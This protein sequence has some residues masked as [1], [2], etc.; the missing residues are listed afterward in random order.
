[1]D[2]L[3]IIDE[4]GGKVVIVRIGDESYR[5]DYRQDWQSFKDCQSSVILN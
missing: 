5:Q 1:M 3:L 2:F 4:N